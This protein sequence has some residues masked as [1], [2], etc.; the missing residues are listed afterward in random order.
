MSPEAA[1]TVE[2]ELAYLSSYKQER[3]RKL[4]KMLKKHMKDHTEKLEKAW[5][6]EQGSLD[7]TGLKEIRF[8]FDQADRQVR[9]SINEWERRKY[10]DVLADHLLDMYD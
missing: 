1:C 10:S 9:N 3:Y 8:E 4:E 5:K 2:S 6:D 7:Y